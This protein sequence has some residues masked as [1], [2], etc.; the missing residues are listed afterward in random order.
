MYRPT[1]VDEDKAFAKVFM[2]FA[3][4]DTGFIVE[5][6]EQNFRPEEVFGEAEIKQWVQEN[7]SPEEIFDADELEKWAE[8]A[9]YVRPHD[10]LPE[11]EL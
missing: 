4:I 3:N 11:R 6:V 10:D 7:Y 9:D 1:T 5:W 2:E 8:N